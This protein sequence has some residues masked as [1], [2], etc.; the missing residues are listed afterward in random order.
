MTSDQKWRVAGILMTLCLTFKSVCVCVCVCW[1]VV[2]V[3]CT[4][5][6]LCVT[7]IYNIIGNGRKIVPSLVMV[8]EHAHSMNFGCGQEGDMECVYR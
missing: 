6:T 1:C 2:H 4:N 5:M 7:C 8:V 3:C